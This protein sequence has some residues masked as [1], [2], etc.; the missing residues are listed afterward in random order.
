MWGESDT[1]RRRRET[2]ESAAFAFTFELNERYCFADR[3]TRAY[4]FGLSVMRYV[5]ASA[6]WRL[7]CDAEY[8]SWKFLHACIIA[9]TRSE[10]DKNREGESGRR[11]Q[12]VDV[13]ERRK[14]D[15]VQHSSFCLPY[16]HDKKP[17]RI[18]MS[19]NKLDEAKRK[20][21]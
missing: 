17:F 19:R 2:S 20:H 21:T 3:V 12:I 11:Y 5:S 15:G 8:C 16:V 9:F 18:R 13:D 4:L 10:R 6:T 14:G 7:F 1:G